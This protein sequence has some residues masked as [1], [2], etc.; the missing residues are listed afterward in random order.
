MPVFLIHQCNPID[1]SEGAAFEAKGFFKS[2]S[3]HTACVG[4]YAHLQEE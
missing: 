3:S 1:F 2:F 4:I